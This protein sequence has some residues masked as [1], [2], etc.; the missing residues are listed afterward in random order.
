MDGYRPDA[1]GQSGMPQKMEKF[2]RIVIRSSRFR[3]CR[4]P[5][6]AK[7]GQV[8]F[9]TYFV[10]NCQSKRFQAVNYLVITCLLLITY[11]LTKEAITVILSGR[12]VRGHLS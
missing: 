9:L 6:Y 4:T 11:E 12:W 10:T 7:P 8:P 1:P 3:A 2:C 5:D